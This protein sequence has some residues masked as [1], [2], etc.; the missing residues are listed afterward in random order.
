M[1]RF[2]EM[3]VADAKN[4][5]AYLRS[6]PPI[7]NE[8]DSGK[9]S[10]TAADA[11]HHGQ[12]VAVAQ[13]C[14]SC[15]GADLGGVT[16]PL[17]GTTVYGP[18]LTPDK[19]TGLGSWSAQQ[20]ANAI[21]KGTNDDGA[22]LC[23]QMPRFSSLNDDEVSG[24]V[25]FL[26]GLPAVSRQSP[27]SSCGSETPD[28]VTQGEAFVKTR[29]CQNC[30]A[31]NLGGAPTCADG[32]PSNL[33]ST[34]LSEWS[35]AQIITATR[36]GVD[37]E[38]A[39]LN[40]GMP[41]YATMSDEEAQDIVAYLRSL[42]PVV[43]PGCADDAPKDAGS[44][45]D[46]ADAGVPVVDA[47]TPAFDAGTPAFDAG[48]PAFDAG[49]P[50]TG[51]TVGSEVVISQIYGG[52]GNVGAAYDTDFVEL[53]NRTSKSV[54]IA[55]WAVQYASASGTSWKSALATVPANVSI[56]AG[57][58]L[59]IA[60]GPTGSHGVSLPSSAIHLSKTIDLA[61]TSGKVALTRTATALTGDCP[62]G[63][64]VVDFVGYGAS[65]CSQGASAVPP[66]SSSLAAFRLALSGA[67]MACV[68]TSV[69]ASDFTKGAPL[70]HGS[71]TNVCS[72]Q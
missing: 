46:D 26:M 48:T 2:K 33:T 69:N 22:A 58:Y 40:R 6:L 21:T 67:D 5:V 44:T 25:A 14:A 66:L 32:D 35:D 29:G 53:H 27:E 15:H 11:A 38:G 4:V 55:G 17:A 9:C 7:S 72:C 18:N 64:S 30:H 54:S 47:G 31:A 45:P 60:V 52:G 71:T 59:L 57:A 13:A 34:G 61:A 51:T 28:P 62:S 41:R 70:P 56:A 43:R 65:S 39:M 20:I 8:V 42:P 63:S 36:T 10:V 49:T 19:A 1:P 23:S 37:D 68:D 12:L 3:S 24:L 16:K 50:C